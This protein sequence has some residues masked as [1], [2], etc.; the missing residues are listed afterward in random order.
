MLTPSLRPK[1]AKCYQ[2][3]KSLLG[4]RVNAPSQRR[5]QLVPAGLCHLL[6]VTALS[7]LR[8][9]LPSSPNLSSQARGIALSPIPSPRGG[10]LKPGKAE[11]ETLI[12]QREKLPN[13][14]VGLK[15]SWFPPAPGPC[16]WV[17]RLCMDLSTS[18]GTRDNPRT[19]PAPG[20][21]PGKRP[22]PLSSSP[23]SQPPRQPP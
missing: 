2:S 6:A 12:W 3:H 13:C 22:Q 20:Q 15:T 21:M 18:G 10:R 8:Q 4:F 14:L 19:V 23:G 5:Q 7:V 17:L 1:A 16:S 9:L 11:A